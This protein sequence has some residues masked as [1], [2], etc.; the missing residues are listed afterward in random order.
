DHVVPDLALFRAHRPEHRAAAL[1]LAALDQVQFDAVL[2][3]QSR[4][5]GEGGVD[6]DGAGQGGRLGVDGVAGHGD[7]IAAGS[8]DAGHGDHHGLLGRPALGGVAVAQVGQPLVQLV[9]GG[10]AA[11]GAVDAE[12]H[13]LD[14]RVLRGPV[15]LPLVVADQPLHD[16]AVH[17]DN[18]DLV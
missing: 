1:D 10:D 12:H 8:G 3:G 9:T 5:V 15:D 7:V 13:G 17:A 18:G 4:G 2:L 14:L 16:Q 11:A 6:A